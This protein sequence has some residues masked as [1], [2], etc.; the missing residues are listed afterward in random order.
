MFARF[1]EL[2]SCVVGVSVA[3]GRDPARL[4]RVRVR[5]EEFGCQLNQHFRGCRAKCL[6]VLFWWSFRKL[7]DCS[8]ADPLTKLLRPMRGLMLGDTLQER[9]ADVALDKSPK[10]NRASHNDDAKA[11]FE[12]PFRR[13]NDDDLK[14]KFGIG[15]FM[16]EGANERGCLFGSFHKSVERKNMLWHVKVDRKDR[17]SFTQ[18]SCQWRAPSRPSRILL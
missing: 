2:V 8:S 4:E 12:R 14:N 7:V 15:E 1:V 10:C 17:S 5:L 3:F 9:F 18:F 16:T 11:G 6:L 13:G